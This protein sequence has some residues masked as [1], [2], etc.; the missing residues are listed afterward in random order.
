MYL[1]NIFFQQFGGL[2]N[3]YGT[4]ILTYG[5]KENG[6]RNNRWLVFDEETLEFLEDPTIVI[7]FGPSGY[8]APVTFPKDWLPECHA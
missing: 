3:H 2:Y 6:D 4:L 8:G 1:T 5:R 7:N